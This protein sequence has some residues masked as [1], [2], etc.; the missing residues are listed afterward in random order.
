MNKIRKLLIANRG[1]IAVRIIHAAK[2][3]QIKTVAI[4][5]ETD[6]CAVHVM[7]ADEVYLVENRGIEPY[8]DMD[9]IMEIAELSEA[10]AI[11]PGYG[12]L[13]ENSVFARE[14]TLRGFIFIGPAYETIALMGDKLKAKE[15]A[16]GSNVPIIPGF[17]IKDKLNQE[18][19]NQAKTIKFPLLIKARSWG[20]R[21]RYANSARGKRF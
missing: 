12:F 18:Q 4:F 1:E 2:E 17:D 5:S 3:L 13:S 16:I 21:K 11:H 10:E 8:L 14:V 7:K 6:R 19:L 15:I 20:R 9:Q